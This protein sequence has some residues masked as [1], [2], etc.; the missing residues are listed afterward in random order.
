MAN[1]PLSFA[2]RDSAFEKPDGQQVETHGWYT[3]LASVWSSEYA[4]LDVRGVSVFDPLPT[5]PRRR[6]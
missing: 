2:W 3:R 5:C 4:S 6:L 1:S